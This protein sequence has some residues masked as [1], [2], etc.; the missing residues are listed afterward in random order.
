MRSLLVA[1]LAVS[2]AAAAYAQRP[3]TLDMTC[4]EARSI[5]ARAGAIV[6]STGRHT[7]DR[8]VAS[9]SYCQ[10]DEYAYATSA[11]TADAR[12]CPLGYRCDSTPPIWR[13]DD[14]FGGRL[15]GR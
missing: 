13:D 12:Q 2:F 9:D 11:P 10:P 6:L 4:R 8:F 14:G 1:V 5:V 7:Y 3:S 15:F